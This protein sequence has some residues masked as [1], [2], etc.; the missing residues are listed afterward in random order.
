[1]TDDGGIER[2][3]DAV[4]DRSAAELV[5]SPSDS[6]ADLETPGLRIGRLVIDGIDVP[7]EAPLTELPPTAAPDEVEAAAAA[8]GV[9]FPPLLARLYTEVADG[10]WGPSNGAVPVR[11][12]QELW[13]SYAVELVEAEDLAPW[14]AGVV[15]FSELDQTLTACID[16]SSPD[17]PIVGFEFDDLDPDD[18]DALAEALTPRAVSLEAWLRAWLA[19]T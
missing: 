8:L 18:P 17:G 7:G 15:P 19:G 4:R 10:G 3:L 11:R 1:M 5:T 13:E 14:P 16:C 2:L 12:L 9:T 6:L